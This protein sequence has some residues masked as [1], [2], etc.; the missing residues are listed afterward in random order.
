QRISEPSQ[1]RRVVPQHV[2]AGARRRRSHWRDGAARVSCGRRSHGGVAT[3]SRRGRDG[4]AARARDPGMAS[5][6]PKTS[7]ALDKLIED[8]L[9]DR[10]PVTFSTFFYDQIHD[11]ELLFPAE[12]KY[13]ERF[14][15][16]LDKTEA[17][18]LDRLFESVRAAERQMGVTDAVW[19]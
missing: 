10:L 16:L 7:P 15:G 3:G 19:P 17:G 14:F 18:E 5:T 11:W 2:A 9:F 1:R 12:Q 8:G 6:R 13:Y 4:G